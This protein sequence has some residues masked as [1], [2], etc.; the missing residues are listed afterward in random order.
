MTAEI[1]GSVLAVMV[2]VLV[3]VVVRQ[4]RR[5]K[6][7]KGQLQRCWQAEEE[8]YIRSQQYLSQ[9]DELANGAWV[10][11]EG[12]IYWQGERWDVGCGMKDV[13]TL[14]KAFIL[15]YNTE[16]EALE[17]IGDEDRYNSV[18]VEFL[19]GMERKQG[20]FEVD[21]EDTDA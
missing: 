15:D 3:V 20:T 10:E 6:D 13:D 11:H 1:A 19:D 2:A 18:K 17:I 12:T 14:T 5:A 8:T 16:A 21:E 7:L 4:R 9:F